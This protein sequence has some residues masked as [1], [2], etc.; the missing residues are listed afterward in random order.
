[1]LPRSPETKL[2][3]WITVRARAE[4]RL[5]DPLARKDRLVAGEGAR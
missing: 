3:T 1:M 2:S 5:N 4:T